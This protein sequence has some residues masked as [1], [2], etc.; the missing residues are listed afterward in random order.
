MLGVQTQSLLQWIKV[1]IFIT[2]YVL[3][4]NYR[5]KNINM[6]PKIYT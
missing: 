1:S 4:M 3:K 2:N 5:G 6:Q